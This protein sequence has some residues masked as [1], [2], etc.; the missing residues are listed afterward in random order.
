LLLAASGDLTG[1]AGFGPCQENASTAAVITHAPT[2]I[3]THLAVL[4]LIGDWSGTGRQ[5]TWEAYH[6]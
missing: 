6:D 5:Q 3:L 2:P 1:S 4:R